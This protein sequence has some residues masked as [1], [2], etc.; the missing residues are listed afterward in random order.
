MDK[1]KEEAVWLALVLCA[2][3]AL[4]YAKES[5]PHGPAQLTE[6]PRCGMGPILMVIRLLNVTF[7]AVFSLFLQGG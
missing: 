2:K 6:D 4:V 5:L 3:L 7:Y 1:A